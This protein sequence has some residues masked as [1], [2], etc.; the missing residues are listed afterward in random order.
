MGVVN[1]KIHECGQCLICIIMI[2][3][4]RVELWNTLLIALVVNGSEQ[5][6]YN[7]EMFINIH[8]VLLVF[9]TMCS[10]SCISPKTSHPLCCKLAQVVALSSPPFNI[11]LSVWLPSSCNAA[12]LL[13]KATTQLKE[14]AFLQPITHYH[15][16]CCYRVSRPGLLN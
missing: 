1:Q 16:L 8:C 7:C 13:A 11:K 9:V 12:P 10:L 4:F 6:T 5:S 3:T 14:V 15:I 2:H